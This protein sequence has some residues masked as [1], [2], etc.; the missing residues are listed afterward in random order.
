[1]KANELRI[2]NYVNTPNPSQSPFRIDSFESHSD[3]FIKVAQRMFILEQEVH[4]L[5]WYGKDIEPIQLTDEWFL[6]FGFAPDGEYMSI[7]RLDCKYCFGYRDWAASWTFYIEY[8]DSPDGKD[9]GVKYPISFD[10]K[11]VHQLQNLY[12][13]LTGEELTIGGQHE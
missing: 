12:L 4:P 3:Y 2:G 6:K 9:D 10:I 5:T 13:A 7:E 8:T 1:M 11:Y